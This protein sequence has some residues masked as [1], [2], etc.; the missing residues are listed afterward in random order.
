VCF[1]YRGTEEERQRS[2]IIFVGNLPYD[3]R[4]QD[5]AAMF[6]RYGKLVKVTIPIDALTTKNKG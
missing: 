4:E 2:T 1:V 5:V 6:D 3:Y